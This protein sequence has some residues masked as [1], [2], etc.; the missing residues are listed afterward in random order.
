[1]LSKPTIEYSSTRSEDA[2]SSQR[3]IRLLIV[4]NMSWYPTVSGTVWFIDNVYSK[5]LE[6]NSMLNLYV[7]GGNPP[8][9]LIRNAE[10][11]EGIKVTG[12]VDDLDWYY[13][14]CDIAVVP[15]F[16]G[17]G[18]KIKVLEAV[19]NH[20]PCVISQFAAKDYAGIEEAAFVAAD[21]EA[22]IKDCSIGSFNSLLE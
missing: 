11:Y 17:T 12:F 7:V 18:A 8:M 16:E 2:Y 14:N 20:I 15:I 3:E 4:G 5:L 13:R 19:G 10:K 9:E 1:M 21:K 22:F 6:S